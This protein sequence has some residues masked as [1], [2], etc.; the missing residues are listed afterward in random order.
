MMENMHKKNYTMFK[1]TCLMLLSALIAIGS[2]AQAQVFALD[3]VPD[4][5][6]AIFADTADNSRTITVTFEPQNTNCGGFDA[7]GR[8]TALA[9]ASRAGCDRPIILTFTTSGFALDTIAFSDLDDFDGTAPRDSFAA[10]VP[11]T[12]TS[13]T[14]EIFSFAN[15]PA[16]ADQA[17]RLVA[18]GAVGTFLA[19]QSGNNPVN[20]SA[21]FTLDTPTTT[22]DIIYDDVEGVRGAAAFFTLDPIGATLN[23]DSDLVTSKSLASANPAPASGDT[24]TYQIDVTNNGPAIATNVNLTDLIPSALTPTTNNGTVTAGTYDAGNGLWSINSIAV[25]ATETLTIEGVIDGAQGG[26][27]ISN[28]SSSA[29]GDGPDPSP[30]GDDLIE[31]FI[32]TSSTDVSTTKTNTPGANGEI[33]QTNDSVTSGQSTAYTIS[34]TNNGPDVAIDTLV[35]DTITAGL[36]CTNSDSVTISGDGI[37]SGSFTIADITGA[38]IT[39]GPLAVGETALLTYSCTV[40]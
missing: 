9:F 29:T 10:S 18:G 2:P 25:G 24:V 17:N 39:L 22:L 31:E 12:W 23:F 26:Q 20:E 15:P 33:D 32:V 36:S 1:I 5:F 37:P 8:A 35:R 3:S 7:N 6:T 11:G 30:G 14:I 4:N 38:G 34:V 27:T 21:S 19:N 28:N 40:N 13:P 16:F